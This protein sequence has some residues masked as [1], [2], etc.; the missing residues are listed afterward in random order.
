MR[1]VPAR[2]IALAAM[3]AL[4]LA[5]R[6]AAAAVHDVVYIGARAIDPE[7]GLDA[8]RNIAIDGDRITAVTVAPI[9]GRRTIDARGLIAAPGFID[10]HSHAT[11]QETAGYQARD[12]VTTRLEL[13]I[14]AYP[15]DRWYAKRAGRELL[16]YGTSVGHTPIR[17]F[18]QKGGGAEGLVALDKPEAFFAGE[19]I[20]RPIPDAQ[21]GRLAPLLEEGL[22]AGAIGIGSGTQYAPGITHK[23]MLDVTRVAGRMRTCVFTHVRYGSLVEPDSTLESVQESIANAAITGACVHVVHINSM[24]MSDAPLMTRLMR[25]AK[26]HGVDVSTETYPWDG[27]VDSIRSVIFDPGWEKRWG[28]GVGDLQSRSTGKRLTQAEFDA[29]R[30]GTGDDGVIMHMNSEAT[31]AALLRDPPV[32]VASD[33]GNIAGANSHPRSAGTF[34]RVLGHYVRETGVLG[35]SEAIRKMALMPAQRLEAFVPAMRRKGRLQAGA[36][37]DIVL[38]DPAT[39]GAKAAYGDAA[40]PSEGFR[41]VMVNGVLVVDQGALVPDVRPGRPVRSE[42]RK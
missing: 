8:V 7:S 32:L 13:E 34:A 31:I 19:E 28:V 10:L 2:M 16:N 15:V 21:Y 11:N 12:G 4:S 25:E 1:P 39:V 22:R 27:S 29:L 6:P 26:A 36:D 42:F 3:A 41:Y 17:Y 33:G 23:E 30:S 24:A 5:G 38:F 35:W 40:R 20:D 9:E 37:A 14:G 18:L